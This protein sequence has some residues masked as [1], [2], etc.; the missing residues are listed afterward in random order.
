[1]KDKLTK[2]AEG[3]SP[4]ELNSKEEADSYKSMGKERFEAAWKKEELSIVNRFT[5]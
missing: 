3:M 4:L 2:A 5:G 1:M